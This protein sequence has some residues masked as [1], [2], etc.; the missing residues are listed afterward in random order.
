M[1][2]DL[3]IHTNISDGSLTSTQIINMAIKQKLDA[4]AFTNHDIFTPITDEQW[5]IADDN[6]LSIIS[7]IEI[8]CL[9]PNTGRQV[10]ILCLEPT[11]RDEL[12]IIANQTLVGRNKAGHEMAEKVC[13]IYPIDIEDILAMSRPSPCLYKQHIMRCL[14]SQGYELFLYGPLFK[15]LF[16]RSTGSCF[17]GYEMPDVYDVLDACNHSGGITIL[18]HPY[19]YDSI[20]LMHKLI[21]E[22]RLDGI[23]VYSVKS[24]FEQEDYLLSLAQDKNLLATGGSDFHGANSSRVSPLG[25]KFTSDETLIK[26]L[27]WNII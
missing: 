27:N 15:Q 17:A 22:K 1:K 18:A 3:H 14:V 9:D 11:N 21:D 6:N 20:E 5:K 4:I 13:N 24:N 2:G 7:G 12:E 25:S 19:E 10:H 16:N 8:T 26:I 23:E